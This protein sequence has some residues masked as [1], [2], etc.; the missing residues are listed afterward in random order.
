MRDL[1]QTMRD[2]APIKKAFIILFFAGLM[3]ALVAVVMTIW[4]AILPDVIGVTEVNYWQMLGIIF[5]SRLLFGA[6]KF[7]N[8]K[9]KRNRRKHFKDK[10]MNMSDE[11][12]ENFKSEWKSRWDK[13]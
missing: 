10:F 12:K 11:E 3:A 8:N 4:N 6:S 13:C 5:L 9:H 7:G 2:A 1:D